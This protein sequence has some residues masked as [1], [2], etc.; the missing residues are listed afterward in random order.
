M[1]KLGNP[2]LYQKFFRLFIPA[3]PRLPAGRGRQ[4]CLLA[5]RYPCHY[6]H[7]NYLVGGE[8]HPLKGKSQDKNPLLTKKDHIKNLFV[9]TATTIMLTYLSRILFSILSF[10]TISSY[11]FVLTPL[12]SRIIL[13]RLWIQVSRDF[14]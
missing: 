7:I 11:P 10:L 2:F 9:F 3:C 12:M 4:A 8:G 5:D 13:Y 6:A 14:M 1:K